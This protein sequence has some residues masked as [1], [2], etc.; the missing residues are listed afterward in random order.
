MEKRLQ[1][2]TKNGRLGGTMIRKCSKCGKTPKVGSNHT[3]WKTSYRVFCS[4]GNEVLSE[5]SEWSV[6][7]A[8][9]KE[10]KP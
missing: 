3:K 4:C 5:K 2:R 6:K 9:N 8:W 10:N 7:V 1:R